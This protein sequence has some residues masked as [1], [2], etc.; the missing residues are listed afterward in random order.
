MYRRWNV[1]LVPTKSLTPQLYGMHVLFLDYACSIQEKN[2]SIN[3][4]TTMFSQSLH[5]IFCDTFLLRCLL[6]DSWQIDT[7]SWHHWSWTNRT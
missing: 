5:F 3:L 4:C 7:Q 2:S 1:P 6:D